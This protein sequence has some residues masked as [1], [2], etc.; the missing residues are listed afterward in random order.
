LFVV[1]RVK[2]TLMVTGRFSYTP[3]VDLPQGRTSSR[4]QSDFSLRYQFLGRRASLSLSLADPFDTARRSSTNTGDVSYV[5]I[6]RS[7]Q[8]LRSA[9]FSFN[10]T[11]G[12]RGR[13][14][15]R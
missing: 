13:T 11:F 7:S 1:G 12:G 10:Y 2:P 3:P 15:G 9:A 6:A 4:E 14:R 5:Q 8:S